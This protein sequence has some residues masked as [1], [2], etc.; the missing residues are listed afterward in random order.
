MSEEFPAPT[1][2]GEF[3][4]VNPSDFRTPLPYEQTP[5]P[6][7]LEHTPSVASEATKIP[8]IDASEETAVVSEVPQPPDKLKNGWNY[9]YETDGGNIVVRRGNESRV[10][11]RNEYEGLRDVDPGEVIKEAT[12]DLNAEADRLVANTPSFLNSEQPA[13]TPKTEEAEEKT[14]EQASEI[15]S[16]KKEIKEL[17]E[18][19]R[20]QNGLLRQLLERDKKPEPEQIPEPGPITEVEAETARLETR[21]EEKGDTTING[22]DEEN[23][24]EWNPRVGDQVWVKK[25]DGTWEGDWSIERIYDKKGEQWLK[26]KKSYESAYLDKPAHEVMM[27]QV[28]NMVTLMM[29]QKSWESRKRRV[30][31]NL[32][33]G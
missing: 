4:G 5:T 8:V 30:G 2:P 20:E 29:K 27:W 13:E 10:L 16:L 28:L 15:E 23:E 21:P 18:L 14:S 22:E 32:P 7:T 24:Y 6:T 12:A 17:R 19:L 25:P 11:D 3:Q 31:R 9:A 26:L 33:I 1:T